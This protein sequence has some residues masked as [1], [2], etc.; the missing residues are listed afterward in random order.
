MSSTKRVGHL[1]TLDPMA[2]GLLL[3][4]SG[5]ATRLAPFYSHNDKTYYAEITLGIESDTY[6]AEGVLVETNRPIP[7]DV[8]EIERAL[9]RF[10]GSFLQMPPAVSAKKVKGVPAYKLVRQNI[11]FELKPVEV[12]IQQLELQRVELPKLQVLVR[13]SAGVYIRSIAHDLGKALGC[14]AILSSLRRLKVGDFSVDD[15][16]SIEQ[17]ESLVKENRLAEAIIPQ[18]EL[19]PHIPA[20]HFSSEVEVQIRQGRDF[21]SSPFVIPSGAPL[22][23]ALN[24]SGD[25]VAMAEI[26]L[27]N[28][29]HPKVVL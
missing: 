5:T 28:L 19:L 29:Y 12:T 1:G 2:T 26:T 13:S 7:E 24:R 14:G 9:D 25:L 16:R 11:E 18:G 4:L 6:D 22:I 17:L 23:R 15:A 20:E 3:L 27:P 8:H 10:R 21:R